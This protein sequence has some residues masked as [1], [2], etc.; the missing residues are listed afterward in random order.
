MRLA[1]PFKTLALVVGA[2]ILGT[3]APARSEMQLELQSGGTSVTLKEASPG[4]GIDYSGQFAST[5]SIKTLSAQSNSSVDGPGVA[6]E[7]EIQSFTV[8]NLTKSQQTLTLTL[9]DVGFTPVSSGSMTISNSASGTFSKGTGSLTFQSVAFD[10][11]AYFQTSGPGTV[12]TAPVTL[13]N[14]VSQ[15]GPTTASFNPNNSQFSLTGILTLTLAAGSEL[16]GFTGDPN[17]PVQAPEP[18]A[19]ALVFSGL[20]ALGIGHWLRRRGGGQA[21]EAAH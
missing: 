10:G 2:A 20:V 14:L 9:S 13:T 12:A 16:S 18:G 1:N 3:A 21:G 17:V 4:A 15:G 6:P 8:K 7:L 11:T 5:F 19:L